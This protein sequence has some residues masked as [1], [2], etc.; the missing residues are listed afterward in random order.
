MSKM[1]LPPSGFA[2]FSS[3]LTGGRWREGPPQEPLLFVKSSK[4]EL[5]PGIESTYSVSENAEDRA[6]IGTSFGGLA[7]TYFAFSRPDIF[8]NTC[9]QAP[10]YW[11]RE[12]IYD[13]VRNSSATDLNI[14]MSVGTAGDNTVEA[15]LMRD[16]FMKKGLDFTYKEVNEGH[17]W[18]AWSTQ[19]D[20]VF[21]QFFGN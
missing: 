3:A 4:Q 16:I 1:R 17:S 7:A 9:I 12:D 21:I 5:I 19:M 6:I 13:L 18:G 10:A 2:P 20:E 14:F 11:Y 8:G 15:R